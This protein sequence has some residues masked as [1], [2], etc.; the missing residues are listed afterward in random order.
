MDEERRGATGRPVTPEGNLSIEPLIRALEEDA[1]EEIRDLLDRARREAD[2]LI[3]EAAAEEEERLERALAERGARL[4][5]EADARRARARLGVRRRVLEARRRCLD[6]VFAGA[7]GRLPEI[8]EGPAREDLA[9]R[10]LAAALDC[11]GERPVEI[12]CPG[13]LEETVRT[14]LAALPDAGRRHLV[15][16]DAVGSG[17]VLVSDDGRLHIDATLEGR[18]ETLRARIEI[19][20]VR[21]LDRL[22]EEGATGVSGTSPPLSSPPT[23]PPPEEAP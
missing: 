4:R 21:T 10:L 7:T 17:L 3:G 5:R 11:T 14:L 12:R 16:D 22:A 6:R 19:E 20:V 13:A 8:F 1:R 23:G 9:R 18:L 2:R 15:V